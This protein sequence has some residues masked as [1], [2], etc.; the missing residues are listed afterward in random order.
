MLF[1]KKNITGT[2]TKVKNV[3]NVNPY[4]IAQLI[5]PQKTTLSPPIKN[6]G[7]LLVINEIKSMLIPIANGIKPNTVVIAVNK[8]GRNLFL[9]A[10]TMIS[11]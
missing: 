5:G 4:I 6:C 11:E 2:M 8:T 10:S 7:S 3:A 9:P 1:I